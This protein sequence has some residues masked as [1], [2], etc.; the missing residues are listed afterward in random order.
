MATTVD[1]DIEEAD[2]NG[3]DVF[4][5]F[6]RPNF[7]DR[8]RE[9]AVRMRSQLRMAWHEVNIAFEKESRRAINGG[10]D[11]PSES[12]KAGRS[13]FSLCTLLTL[14]GIPDTLVGIDLLVVR[15]SH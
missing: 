4:P 13:A 15:L 12:K 14:L 6:F 1:S 9:T 7:M 3:N 11:D 8:G 10:A 5:A 2:G